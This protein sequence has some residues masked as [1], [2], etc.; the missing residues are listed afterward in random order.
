MKTI[1]KYPLLLNYEVALSMPKGAV[2][3]C[4]QVQY[5]SPCLWALVDDQAGTELRTFRIAGTGH[6][7]NEEQTLVYVG[8]F[9]MMEGSLV[10]HVFE[11]TA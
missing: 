1:H 5:K 3:L 4:V 7:L 9:Q 2:P 11:V 10:F 6:P 8:T